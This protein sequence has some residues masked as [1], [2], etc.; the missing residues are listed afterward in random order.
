MTDG[1][2]RHKILVRCMLLRGKCCSWMSCNTFQFTCSLQAVM[3]LDIMCCLAEQE[4]FKQCGQIRIPPSIVAT[5]RAASEAYWDF[6]RPRQ[7]LT[8]RF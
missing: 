8:P 1:W 5:R 7:D 2:V 3:P 4:W 6:D